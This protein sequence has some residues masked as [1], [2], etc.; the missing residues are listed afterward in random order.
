MLA[1]GSGPAAAPAPPE[2]K[3]TRRGTKGRAK[4]LARGMHINTHGFSRMIGQDTDLQQRAVRPLAPAGAC[5][6]PPPPPPPPAVLLPPPGARKLPLRRPPR[7]GSRA[8]QS[9]SSPIRPTGEAAP[10]SPSI[11]TRTGRMVLS[12]S[13]PASPPRS[14]ASFSARSPPVNSKSS[15][16]F[17]TFPVILVILYWVAWYWPCRCVMS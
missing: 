16:S 11:A 6:R 8:P 2:R 4:R 10:P 14:V 17:I 15:L 13:P 9:A 1:P 7:C 12:P 5:L 3:I